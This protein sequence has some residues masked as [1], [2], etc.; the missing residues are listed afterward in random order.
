MNKE[1][2]TELMHEI[3]DDRERVAEEI[4]D[5]LTGLEEVVEEETLFTEGS[6]ALSNIHEMEGAFIEAIPCSLGA[7]S[8]DE[9]AAFVSGI[10]LGMTVQ[11]QIES[12]NQ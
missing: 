2:F 6:T 12:N 11:K 7:L 9:A 1:R 10:W 5:T 8:E 3:I 4:R